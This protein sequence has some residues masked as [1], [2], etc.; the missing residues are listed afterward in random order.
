KTTIS[1]TLSL[2]EAGQ[3]IRKLTHPIAE[4]HKLIQENIQLATQYKKYVLETNIRRLSELPSL[5]DIDKRINDLTHEKSIIE[6][7]YK[8]LSKFFCANATLPF[9]DAILQYHSLFIKEEQ[10]KKKAGRQN[11]DVIQGLEQMMKVYE[12]EIGCV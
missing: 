1:N 10:M 9:N 3:L 4:T 5:S 6:D 11:D 2:N 12:E 7:V 8:K